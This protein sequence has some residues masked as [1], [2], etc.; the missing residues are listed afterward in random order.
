[1]SDLF[2]KHLKKQSVRAKEKLL[3][4]LGKAER[5]TD[6]IF[7]EHN[8]NFVK[9]QKASERM[10]KQVKEYVERVKALAA[11][12]KA[13]H[14]TI[15]DSYD[16]Q[17]DEYQEKLNEKVLSPLVTYN[18]HFGDLKTKIA[19][20][21]RK[22]VDYD[23][24]RHDTVKTNSKKAVDEVKVQKAQTELFQAEKM[25]KDLNDELL[26]ELPAFYD[27][28]ITFLVE[29][30]QALFNS[31]SVF[32][33]DASKLNKQLCTELDELG[34]ALGSLR[35]ARPVAA[36]SPP[37]VVV[38]ADSLSAA[39]TPSLPHSN[40][41]GES[42]SATSRKSEEV[43]PAPIVAASIYPRISDA[44][45]GDGGKNPFDESDESGGDS[46]RS[47]KD[48][49]PPVAQQRTISLK[50]EPVA[51]ANTGAEVGK[52]GAQPDGKKAVEPKILYKVRATHRYAAEDTDEMSF[53]AGEV[54]VV[55]APDASEDL[56]DGWLSG[57][58]ESDGKKG[59]FPANFTKQI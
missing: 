56:D 10:H 22:L 59:V 1:M 30:L 46:K 5:T 4:S 13:L 12:S 47:S 36:K 38:A 45:N 14:E 29:N 33:S 49:E 37:P 11:A 2:S 41:G 3:E 44:S 15:R 23:S 21:G 50:T 55:V 18:A 34:N 9:Q 35:V 42:P 25:Y 51:A 39:S 31:E 43:N 48:E 57:F 40:K 6:D 8:A 17:W 52:D 19:K 32:H 58:K 54:I 16:L 20:R 24:A 53:E 28:R 7:E 26:D 27:S